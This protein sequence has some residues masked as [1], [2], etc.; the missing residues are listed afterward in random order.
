MDEGMDSKEA[1]QVSIKVLIKEMETHEVKTDEDYKF[2][3]DWVRRNKETQAL[4]KSAWE[5]D[6]IRTKAAYDKVLADRDALMDPLK[7]AESIARRK[8]GAYLTEKE[9]ARQEAQRK[10]E[11]EERK[12]IEDKRLAEAEKLQA[13]GKTEKA[14]AV[15]DK[16]VHV[17]RAAITAAT[18][19]KV[20]KGRETWTV[21]V[22]DK[23]AF[24]A[25]AIARPILQNIIEI[26][27]NGL[28]NYCKNQGITEMPG[29]IITKTW[30][31]IV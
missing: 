17:S 30:T 14:D 13:A 26:D 25:E 11:E 15:L 29:L 24:L 4:W 2:L 12:K 3:E 8:M 10:L 23:A 20:G 6:R 22:S 16:V 9:K 31:P 18:P 28:A 5:E 7:D 21:E 19:A 1:L 27:T